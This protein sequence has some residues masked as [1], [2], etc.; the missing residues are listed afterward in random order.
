[1]LE[2]LPALLRVLAAPL[3]WLGLVRSEVERAELLARVLERLEVSARVW[4]RCRCRRRRGRR[5]RGPRRLRDVAAGSVAEDES[6][7]D[8]FFFLA[9]AGR[10]KDRLPNFVRRDGETGRPAR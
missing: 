10:G 2:R 6:R 1:L 5:R 8:A 9:L 7:I 4:D 3:A